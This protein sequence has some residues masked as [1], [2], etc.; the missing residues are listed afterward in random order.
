MKRRTKMLDKFESY[1]LASKLYRLVKR[2]RCKS[3]VRDQV[4]RAC[5][6]TV[7]NLAEGSAKGT[8]KERLRF[9]RI[10]LASLRE[11]QAVL[12]VEDFR[13][14]EW[15]LADRLGGMLYRLTRS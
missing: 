5:L 2:L 11:V 9:Y 15:S 6:S 1:Q 3:Y 13:S 10:A 12:D 14:E 4:Q 7:L 8:H